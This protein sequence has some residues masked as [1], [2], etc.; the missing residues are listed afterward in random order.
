MKKNV[1]MLV[2]ICMLFIFIS[3]FITPETNMAAHEILGVISAFL[4]AIHII[5]N[6]NWVKNT[7]KKL[8]GGKLNKKSRTV[9]IYVIGLLISIVTTVVT[10]LLMLPEASGNID[11]ALGAL[12][13][14]STKIFVVFAILHIKIHWSYI[15]SFFKRK[16]MRT[17]RLEDLSCQN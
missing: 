9:L 1:K 4:V 14:I 15:K 13:S 5:L 11:P 17:T 7:A 3:L 16:K 6:W 10:G 8:T 2:N 12:H